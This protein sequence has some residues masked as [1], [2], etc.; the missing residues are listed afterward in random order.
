MKP[1]D[2]E[3][4]NKRGSNKTLGVIGL[5]LSLA[6]G[7]YAASSPAEARAAPAPDV[8]LSTDQAPPFDLREEDV[9]DVRMSS[10]RF[11]TARNSRRMRSRK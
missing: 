2:D 5:S 1:S 11:S 10:F 6:G 3:P 7:L 9:F 4:K 8:A